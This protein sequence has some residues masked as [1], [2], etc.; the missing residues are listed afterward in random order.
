MA[1]TITSFEEDKHIADMILDGAGRTEIVEWLAARGMHR[2]SARRWERV[3]RAQMG[4]GP[5]PRAVS[6]PEGED[7]GADYA[8]VGGQ[9]E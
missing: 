1:R 6:W 4:F 8:P 5:S 9:E 7:A 3:I 2:S